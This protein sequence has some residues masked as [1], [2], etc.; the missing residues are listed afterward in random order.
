MKK[1]YSVSLD[2]EAVEEL[3]LNLEMG[4]KFSPLLSDILKQ[5][6]KEKKETTQHG[7]RKK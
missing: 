4:Q 7:K 2:Q 3:L 1:T 6:N 5:Y